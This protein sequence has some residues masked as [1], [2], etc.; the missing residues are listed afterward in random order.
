MSPLRR[1]IAFRALAAKPRLGL[2]VKRRLVL[3]PSDLSQCSPANSVVDAA[4]D[5]V[6]VEELDLLRP[7]H[8]VAVVRF[9]AEA[10]APGL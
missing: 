5:V 4:V 10:G 9:V 1:R 7:A 8:V 2:A 6:A 3:F